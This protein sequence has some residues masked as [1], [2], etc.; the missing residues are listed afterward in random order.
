MISTQARQLQLQ[1]SMLGAVC[2]YQPSRNRVG[3][4]ADLEQAV[5]DDIRAKPGSWFD[6]KGMLKRFWMTVLRCDGTYAGSRAGHWS[7]FSP[8]CS[9][10]SQ[11]YYDV[12][13][14]WESMQGV[15][16]PRQHLPEQA[17]FE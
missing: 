9:K 7:V 12:S 14:V 8:S 5:L 17:V 4:A 3:T 10:H 16:E 13:Q 2:R 6:Y 1:E 11:H 15:V